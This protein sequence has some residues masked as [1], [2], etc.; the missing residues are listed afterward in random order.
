M[1]SLRAVRAP[2][3]C[4]GV[5]DGYRD[6]GEAAVRDSDGPRLSL[7][8]T[9]RGLAA[10]FGR[11]APGP[12]GRCSTRQDYVTRCTGDAASYALSMG[13]QLGRAGSLRVEVN[14]LVR[15]VVPS[16]LWGSST[17]G[18][19]GELPTCPASTG[20]R[21]LQLAAQDLADGALR[22][23]GP[24]LDLPRALVG[25]ERPAAVVDDLLE[26]TAR[27]PGYLGWDG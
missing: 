3:S 26:G 1:N 15:T 14:P 10:S 21:H 22:Q 19:G 27:T 24:E 8:C 20:L 16:E 25:R 5:P 23:R 12:Q 17:V 4:F 2:S 7:I 9:G 6:S 18:N 11:S 13:H